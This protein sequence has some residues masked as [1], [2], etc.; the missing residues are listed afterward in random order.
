METRL[1]LGPELS[2]VVG[3]FGV[4]GRMD[5]TAP[6]RQHDAAALERR[7]RQDEHVQLTELEK[8]Q[9][10]DASTLE[11]AEGISSGR[12][13]SGLK[14][15]PLRE[16]LKKPVYSYVNSRGFY[17]GIQVDGTVI[18]EYGERIP[19]EKILRGEVPAQ[20]PAGMWPAGAR[21][22]LE[23][24]KGAVAWHGSHAADTESSVQ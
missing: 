16:V 11:P 23:I 6:T 19:V 3:P 21:T 12:K 13:S 15:S 14:L 17:D 22:L 2:V 9:A 24:L 8:V 10:H 7:R 20:G 1:S 18:T 5:F 4:G